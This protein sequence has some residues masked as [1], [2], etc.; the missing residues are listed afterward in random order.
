MA[1]VPLTSVLMYLFRPALLTLLLLAGCATQTDEVAMPDATE[2]TDSTEA[3]TFTGMVRYVGLEG[4]FYALEADDGTSY[5]PLNLP[6][7]FK[8]DGLRVRVEAMPKPEMMSMR[9]YGTIIEIQTM[10]KL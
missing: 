9:Q 4:G 3:L 1:F 10:V 5:D 7:E 6:D 8:E 2:Q